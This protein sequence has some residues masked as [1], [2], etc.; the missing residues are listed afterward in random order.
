[1]ESEPYSLEDHI[2]LRIDKGRQLFGQMNSSS[3]FGS[4]ESGSNGAFRVLNLAPIQRGPS[5]TTA[6][7][8]LQYLSLILLVDRMAVESGGQLVLRAGRRELLRFEDSLKLRDASTPA[9]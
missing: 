7:E 2:L 8:V 5:A 4:Y 3:Y 6:P 1:M 9:N